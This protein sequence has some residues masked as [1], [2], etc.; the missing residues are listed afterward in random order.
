M[1]NAPLSLSYLVFGSGCKLRQKRTICYFCTCFTRAGF[2]PCISKGLKHQSQ[3]LTLLPFYMVDKISLQLV[4]YFKAHSKYVQ[5]S[6]FLLLHLLFQRHTM[7]SLVLK[8]I[9]LS[10]R[11][12]PLLPHHRPDQSLCDY[13]SSFSWHFL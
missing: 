12:G 6:I 10:K 1:M 3:T 4:S 9:V 13:F 7:R 8:C 2:V 5:S 11:R